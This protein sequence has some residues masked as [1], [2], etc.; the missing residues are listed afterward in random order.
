M[1]RKKQPPRYVMERRAVRRWSRLR[2]YFGQEL[3]RRGARKAVKALCS[4]Q[5]W[6]LLV[7][8]A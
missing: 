2:G 3:R 4:G 1:S 7:A 5:L 8:H 6:N